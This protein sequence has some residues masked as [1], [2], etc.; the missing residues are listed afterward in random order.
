[1]KIDSPPTT[2]PVNGPPIT[3]AVNARNAT[4]FTFGGP[5]ASAI[6]EATFSPVKDA[7]RVRFL[8]TN[9][10]EL[11]FNRRLATAREV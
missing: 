10:V 11:G 3:P 7:I 1:M 8:T 5:P 9:V 2:S 4:G 6:L